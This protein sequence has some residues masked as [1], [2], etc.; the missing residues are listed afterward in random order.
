[1]RL[2]S[3]CKCKFQSKQFSEVREQTLPGFD[4]LESDFGCVFA[5]PVYHRGVSGVFH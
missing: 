4:M 5:Q 1:M 3:I 2:T